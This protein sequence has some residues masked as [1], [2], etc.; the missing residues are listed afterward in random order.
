MTATYPGYTHTGM[1]PTFAHCPNCG[2]CA[3]CGKADHSGKLT[4]AAD[5]VPPITEPGW[6]RILDWSRVENEAA[7]AEIAAGDGQDLI[8]VADPK[9]G[10]SYQSSCG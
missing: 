3:S 6:Y 4:T 9:A 8:F 7:R 1:L 10:A 2:Y 5:A